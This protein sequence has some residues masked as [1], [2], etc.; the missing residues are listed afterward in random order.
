MVYD[1]IEKQ[2]YESDSLFIIPTKGLRLKRRDLVYRLDSESICL[3]EV[4]RNRK[5]ENLIETNETSIFTTGFAKKTQAIE[6]NLL[7]EF[8]WPSTKLNVKSANS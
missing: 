3:K 1:Y 8:Q 6:N 5:N 7:S 2:S 4:T